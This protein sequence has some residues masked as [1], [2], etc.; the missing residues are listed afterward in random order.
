MNKSVLHFALRRICG[1]AL[2][3]TIGL[4]LNGCAGILFGSAVTGAAVANDTRTTGSVIED[5]SIELKATELIW[6]DP[7]LKDQS[8]ISTTSYNQIVLLTG[9]T[10]TEDLRQRAEAKVASIEK[11]RHVYNELSIAAPNSLTTRSSDTVL[12]A[13]VK[14]KLIALK[15]IDGTKVK[16]VT[17]NGVVYLMGLLAGTNAD[18]AASAASTVGGV[19]KVVKLFEAPHS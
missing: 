8:H 12:T 13:K 6:K 2:L 16:V 7:E 3:G 15:E 17:E 10:P 18:L 5:Q 1:V 11:V 19:Q 14:T 4:S 9:Q